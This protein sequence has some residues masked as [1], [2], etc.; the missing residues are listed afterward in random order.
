MNSILNITRTDKEDS[1]YQKEDT[2]SRAMNILKAENIYKIYKDGKI[3]LEV[4][5]D[6]SFEVKRGEILLIIGPSFRRA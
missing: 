3:H 4:L 1:V 5:K 6:V 2:Y